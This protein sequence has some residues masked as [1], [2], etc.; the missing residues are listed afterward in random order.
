MSSAEKTTTARKFVGDE[1]QFKGKYASTVLETLGFAYRPFKY[2][3]T[4]L[5]VCGFIG[6]LLML[7][8]ANLVSM[9]ADPKIRP[10]WLVDFTSDQFIALLGAVTVAGFVLISLYRVAFSRLSAQAISQLYDE[11]TLRASRLPMTFFDTQPVG[12]IVT[13]F[14]SDYGN[15][16]RL[17]GGP[18]AEF[19]A[20]IFDLIS[21]C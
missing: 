2:R 13:R 19:F 18:L 20:I 15:V 6:R 7:G 14:S 16:F 21:M 10:S 11:V 5:L 8:N 3:I 1:E 4:A 9:W 12:R 17:F